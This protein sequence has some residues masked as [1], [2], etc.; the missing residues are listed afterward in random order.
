VL[1]VSRCPKLQCGGQVLEHLRQQ[2]EKDLSYLRYDPLDLSYDPLYGSCDKRRKT[3]SMEV[4]SR[5]TM[6][7]TLKAFLISKVRYCNVVD[8]L[9]Y[10][11]FVNIA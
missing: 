5:L 7:K 4:M 3:S 2:A 6:F 9:M 11:N 10:Q 1:N 8:F